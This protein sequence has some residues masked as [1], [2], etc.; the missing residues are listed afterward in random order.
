[1]TMV[2]SPRRDTANRWSARHP[3]L[4][5]LVAGTLMTLVLVVVDGVGTVSD[6]LISFIPVS[7][8]CTLTALSERRRRK[9]HN[10]PF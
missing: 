1:M 7:V 4:L 9:K 6:M 3:L 8:L 5:G 10:L 2:V